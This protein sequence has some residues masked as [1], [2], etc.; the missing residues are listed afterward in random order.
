VVG[1]VHGDERAGLA[2]V[3]ELRRRA[4]AL[5]GVDLWVIPTTNPDGGAA[6]TRQ[7]ARGVDLNR[8][9]PADWRRLPRGTFFS[10]SAPLSEPESKVTYAL[11]RKL[12]PAVS[13]W[14]HQHAS[15]V[16]ASGGD[17]AVQRRYAQLVGLP[18]RRFTRPPGSITTWTNRTFRGTTAF[19][20]ELPAGALGAASAARHARAVIDAV[21]PPRALSARIPARPRIIWRPIPYGAARRREMTAYAQRHSGLATSRLIGPN[22]IVEHWTDGDSFASAF[23]TFAAS[24]PDPELHELPGTCSHFVIDRS[25]RIYQLVALG[26]MCRHAYGMNWTSIGIEHVGRSDAAVLGDAA[27]L[28]ASIRL[29][30]WLRCR[31][32][33]AVGDVVGHAETYGSPWFRERVRKYLPLGPHSDMG[34]AAMR[35]YRALLSQRACT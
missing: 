22:A 33:I 19:V 27:Q 29:T 10:G 28:R 35:R 21:R 32:D 16:D 3:R 31:Y 15:L 26:L 34:P 7:N 4:A 23:N 20:V 1:Y 2:I 17:P 13:I 8:N 30:S 11:L 5:R 6:G 14:Y 12:R 18:Y 25:G 9:F 24:A